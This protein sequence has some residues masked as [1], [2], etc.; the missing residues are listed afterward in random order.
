MLYKEWDSPSLVKG[1]SGDKPNLQ[2]VIETADGA[3]VY[4]AE[5]VNAECRE[6]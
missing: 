3:N 4:L 1:A 6:V 2:I 5:A